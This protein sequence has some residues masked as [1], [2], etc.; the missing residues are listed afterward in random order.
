MLYI[1]YIY[2]FFSVQHGPVQVNK[3]NKYYI[4]VYAPSSILLYFSSRLETGQMHTHIKTILQQYITYI[5]TI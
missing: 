1:L 2:N 5:V 3:Y 4:S